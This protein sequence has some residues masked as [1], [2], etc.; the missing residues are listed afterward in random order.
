MAK[1]YDAALASGFSFK[2]QSSCKAECHE[3]EK[4][5]PTSQMTYAYPKGWSCKSHANAKPVDVAKIKAAAK[6]AGRANRPQP[7]QPEKAKPVVVKTNECP[8]HE[9]VERG[10]MPVA[11]K[12]T[13]TK[14]VRGETASG[15]AITRKVTVTVTAALPSVSVYKTECKKEARAELT[16]VAETRK[17]E[18][19]LCGAKN[20]KTVG[21]A[22]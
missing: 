20:V 8:V 6:A 16:K 10:K 21:Y 15:K 17:Y 13:Y 11:A 1:N 12:T 18:A 4:I 5:K 7:S 14:T 2:S 22:R 19:A 3:C 9:R